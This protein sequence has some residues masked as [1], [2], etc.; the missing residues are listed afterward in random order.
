MLHGQLLFFNATEE[1][2]T[3]KDAFVAAA[4]AMHAK[5]TEIDRRLRAPGAP[6]LA[7][8]DGRL[9]DDFQAY[10]GM[11]Y[12]F[13]ISDGSGLTYTQHYNNSREWHFHY[14]QA[15]ERLP[16]PRGSKFLPH[17]NPNGPILSMVGPQELVKVCLDPE[18]A[19]E[20]VT[21]PRDPVAEGYYVVGHEAVRAFFEKAD[22][23]KADLLLGHAIRMGYSLEGNP[24]A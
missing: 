12:A 19:A 10:N 15:A 22:G 14:V 24:L 4:Q 21:W 20:R 3:S 2:F 18:D 23:P 17:Q 8:S 11:R 13:A 7:F 6:I 1:T 9:T 5:L 16:K